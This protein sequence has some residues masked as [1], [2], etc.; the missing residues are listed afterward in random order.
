MNSGCPVTS[1]V[2]LPPARNARNVRN[3][4]VL[5]NSQDA[6]ARRFRTSSQGRCAYP[7]AGSATSLCTSPPEGWM[8]SEH[9]ILRILSREGRGV[10][11]CWEKLKPQ[12]P[13]V[14][15]SLA[16]VGLRIEACTAGVACP[17]VHEKNE[18]QR[19]GTGEGFRVESRSHGQQ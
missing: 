14:P 15:I 9:S 18:G 19:K 2:P 10:R 12:G 3:K 5:R 16:Q 7:L 4:S 1:S 13:K 17:S 8:R 11:L 6:N